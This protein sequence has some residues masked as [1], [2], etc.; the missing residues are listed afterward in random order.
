MMPTGQTKGSV[1]KNE[2]SFKNGCEFTLTIAEDAS[3]IIYIGSGDQS[4]E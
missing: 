1:D 3:S 4:P 2:C